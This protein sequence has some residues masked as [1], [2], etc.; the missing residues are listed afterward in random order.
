MKPGE[1]LDLAIGRFMDW[2]WCDRGNLPHYSTNVAAAWQIVNRLENSGC[3]F[4]YKTMSEGKRGH[5]VTIGYLDKPV[6]SFHRFI[7]KQGESV[8]HAICLATLEF[9]NEKRSI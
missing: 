9:I 5:F 4:A 6:D 3:T 1:E 8:A 7:T 2:K